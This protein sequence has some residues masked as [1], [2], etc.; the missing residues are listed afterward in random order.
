M[1]AGLHRGAVASGGIPA[2]SQLLNRGHINHTVV[3]VVHHLWHITL[4]EALIHTHRV[5][6]QLRLARHGNILLHVAEHLLLGVIHRHA[7]LEVIHQT[8]GLVHRTHKV[9]HVL[10]RTRGGLV[11][12]LNDELH[13]RTQNIEVGI[14]DQNT[15]LNQG[16]ISHVKAGHLAVNPNN[17]F[18]RNTHTPTLPPF[19]PACSFACRNV[20]KRSGTCR[21]AV[22]VVL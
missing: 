6:A 11:A 5:A 16:V 15:H 21:R 14:G 7:V 10:H 2:R 18:T 8:R 3:Q 17:T 19:A 12:G 13:A 20:L 22:H 9:I 4:Q 1:V